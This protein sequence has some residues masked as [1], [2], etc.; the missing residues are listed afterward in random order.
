MR[1]DRILWQYIFYFIYIV[2]TK[3]ELEAKTLPNDQNA[4]KA[5]P[6]MKRKLSVSR[7]CLHFSVNGGARERDSESYCEL[8]VKE[9]V[10]G[11]W[12]YIIWV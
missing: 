2:Q 9:V 5:N 10:F 4:N 12:T 6:K 1:G 3:F 11:G 7:I 8:G